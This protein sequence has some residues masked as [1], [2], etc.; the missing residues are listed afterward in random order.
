MR[1]PVTKLPAAHSLPLA[2]WPVPCSCV[3]Q[4]EQRA[5][6]EGTEAG[7]Y[8][9]TAGEDE[10][11]AWVGPHPSE[12]DA[13]TKG[14]NSTS[15]KRLLLNKCQEQFNL[16]GGGSHRRPRFCRCHPCSRAVSASGF[17]LVP[18]TSCNLQG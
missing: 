4:V 13:L 11:P 16:V 10:E 2:P 15:F 8:Y 3:V 12:E 5:G 9:T 17:A 7:W 6:G 1:A 14:R 18:W